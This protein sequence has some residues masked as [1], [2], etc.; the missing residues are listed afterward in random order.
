MSEAPPNVILILADQMRGDCLGV[1]GHPVLETP[2]LD[3]LA[4]RGAYFPK[5]YSEVPSCLPARAILWT[6]MNQWHTGILGMGRGQG[7]IP[8]DFPHTLAGE[9]Q[10]AGYQTHLV[11]KG[12]LHPPTGLDG[13]RVPRA[14]R[15]G[16]ALSGQPKGRLP[17]VVRPGETA[18]HHPGRP[19]CGLELLDGPAVAH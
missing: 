8:N 16:P 18:R 9:F 5:A 14:G 12:A 4:A 6:G 10:K 1:A 7:P 19:R 17:R 2:H 13:V 15:V 3:E 11:G